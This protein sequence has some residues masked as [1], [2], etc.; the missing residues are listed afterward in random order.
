MSGH[1]WQ[2]QTITTKG[3]GIFGA[4]LD[5]D[6]LMRQLNEL[7]GKGWELVCQLPQQAGH[8]SAVKRALLLKRPT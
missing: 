2:Y 7:G 1:R 5:T 8:V 3:K 4:S 6:D